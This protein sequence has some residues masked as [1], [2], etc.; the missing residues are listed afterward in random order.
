M[1]YIQNLFFQYQSQKEGFSLHLP[2]WKL[3]KGESVV[4]YGASGCG[5]S[6]LLKCISGQLIPQRG[7]V[8]ISGTD[9]TKITEEKRRL[10]RLSNIGIVFQDYPLIPYLNAL[11]NVLLPFR[12]HPALQIQDHNREYAQ[13]LLQDLGLSGKEIRFPHQLSQGEKQ[14]VAICRALVVQPKIL[15]AD[16]PTAG[17]DPKRSQDI[18][19]ILFE[20]QKRH[21][22]SIIVVTHDESVKSRFAHT[23]D[24]TKLQT[25]VS[26]S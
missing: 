19:D 3:Q 18:V 23:L 15:L 8:T 10:H 16:E 11:E 4:F 5:K 13:K 1:I 21:E 2:S 26:S 25:G 24:I 14:R 9:I 20:L 12:I 7:S 22:L 17:L 6:T